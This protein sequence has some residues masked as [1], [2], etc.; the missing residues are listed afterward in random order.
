MTWVDSTHEGYLTLTGRL[1]EQINRGGEKISPR[2]IDEVLLDHPAVAQAVTFG[3]ADPRLGEAVAAAVVAAPQSTPAERDLRQFVAQRLAVHKVPRRVV[4]VDRLPIGP[5]GK[6]KRVGLAAALGLDHPD[7]LEGLDAGDSPV[8][9]SG[10]VPASA[11]VAASAEVVEFV[12]QHWSEVLGLSQA[13]QPDQHFLDLGGDSMAAARLL[14]ALSDQLDLEISMLDL[15]D[16]PTVASQARAGGGPAA[17]RAV[18]VTAG[19]TGAELLRARLARRPG[20]G[21]IPPHPGSSAP[22]TATQEG[23]WFEAQVDPTRPRHHRP[24]VIRWRGPVDRDRLLDALCRLVAVHAT[25]T[26]RY[27]MIG[28]RP[29]QQPS[30]TPSPGSDGRPVRPADAVDL[31]V[32]DARHDPQRGD[33]AVLDAATRVVDLAQAAPLAATLVT[34]ADDDHL[35][36]LAL[37]HLALDGP[38]ADVLLADLA[39]AYGGDDPGD[40]AAGQ[41]QPW[42]AP[43]QPRPPVVR[44][45]GRLAARPGDA[46]GSRGAAGVVVADAGP[47]PGLGPP[48]AGPARRTRPSTR[49]WIAP[50]GSPAG[51]GRRVGTV[52]LAED[53]RD[54]GWVVVPRDVGD[55]LRSLARVES[56]TMHAVTLAAFQALWWSERGADDLVVGMAVNDRDHPELEAVVGCFVRVLPVRLRAAPGRHRPRPGAPGLGPDPGGARPPGGEPARDHRRARGAPARRGGHRGGRRPLPVPAPGVGPGADGSRCPWSW[57]R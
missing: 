44:R 23:M 56:V 4:V 46:R 13:P 48:R 37:S 35:L 8:Q 19:E 53:G 10:E 36:V 15:F 2:E 18:A 20:P 5:S 16:R 39:A 57:R 40:D 21:S 42:D 24:T 1:K 29:R 49:P 25:L 31:A 33:R 22:L 30:R 34:R 43:A 9:V 51:A 47:P 3:V 55:A 54:L 45:L 28:L 6:L 27:P 17:R 11:E 32:L 41:D 38:S 14:A 50:G 26:T 7:G 12:A 52:R